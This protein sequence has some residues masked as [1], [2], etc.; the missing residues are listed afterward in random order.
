MNIVCVKWGKKYSSEYVHKLHS[1]LSRNMTEPFDFW[2]YTDDSTDLE[3]IQVIP[4]TSDLQGVWP[5]IELFKHFVEGDTIYFDL[6]IVILNPLERLCSVKTRTVSVLYSQWKSDYF[7]PYAEKHLS[8]TLYNSSIMKWSGDQGLNIY[9]HFQSQKDRILVRYHE[10]LDRYFFN[11]PVDIDILPTSIAY[12]YHLG[13]RY[14]KDDEPKKLRKD[15]EVCILNNGE[16]NDKL[17][18]TWIKDYWK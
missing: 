3:N 11:D 6:D 17:L 13:A 10:G 9:K 5:K 12:S 16:K 4:I 18:G 2:C 1:M 15:Y 8:P 7:Y 14:L